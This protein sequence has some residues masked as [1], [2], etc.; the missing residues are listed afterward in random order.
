MSPQAT[1]R[2]VS[3]SIDRHVRSWEKPSDHVPV[4]IELAIEAT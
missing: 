1:D 3:A 4:V 2:F